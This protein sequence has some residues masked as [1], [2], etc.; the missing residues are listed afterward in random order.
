MM[1]PIP[2]RQ[3][4]VDA[5]HIASSPTLGMKEPSRSPAALGKPLPRSLVLPFDSRERSRKAG[6]PDEFRQP[7][8][9]DSR[10]QGRSPVGMLKKMWKW[11]RE[12]WDSDSCWLGEVDSHHWDNKVEIRRRLSSQP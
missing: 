8:S 7:A 3:D 4:S 2:S 11:W 6:K 1:R 10:T 9:A 5:R 12:C